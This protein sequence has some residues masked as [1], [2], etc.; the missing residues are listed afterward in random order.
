MDSAGGPSAAETSSETAGG[1]GGAGG[2]MKSTIGMISVDAS[3]VSLP[4][5]WTKARRFSLQNP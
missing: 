5:Y 2:A 1:A 4:L 3:S